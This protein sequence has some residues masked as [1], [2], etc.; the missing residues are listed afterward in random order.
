MTATDLQ[1]QAE[2]QTP[3]ERVRDFA[4]KLRDETVAVRLKLTAFGR[5][6]AI[7]AEQAAEAAGVFS[8]NP[9]WFRGS[10]RLLNDK[11]DQFRAVVNVLRL[12]REFWVCSS[13]PYPDAGIRLMKRE[14]LQAF[15]DQIE[16]FRGGLEQATKDLE[17]VYQELL[18]GAKE[19]LKDLFDAENYPTT[20]MGCWS[21]SVEY[22][23]V[24]PPAYLKQIS[25]ELYEQ[26]AALIEAK[27]AS[28][29]AAAEQSFAAEFAKVVN[30]LIERLTPADVLLWTYD[31]PEPLTMSVDDPRQT[32]A[33][34]TDV[35]QRGKI[36]KWRIGRKTISKKHDSP[37]AADEW[38]RSV[39]CQRTGSML[40]RRKMTTAS[41]DNLNE[42]FER[43]KQMSVGS[44]G[45][46][47]ALIGRAQEAI[48]GQ[49]SDGLRIAPDELRQNIQA[50]MA[51]IAS[52]LEGMVVPD[53]GGRG[54]VWED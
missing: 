5:R 41:V 32:L 50:T 21:I 47:N 40:E 6:R 18:A 45:E 42:F 19:E 52:R 1:T 37:E 10:K 31:G 29:I 39:G 2:T 3:A 26:Q 49:T 20:L 53:Q 48:A 38:L 43:F 30:G 22:P 12:A 13:T 46:L 9:E 28:A 7:S 34:A 23:S 15:R 17:A 8:A 16:T 27:F 24:D 35:E 36:V 33:T 51:E 14:K 44:N 25:P 11:C 4:K 54:I